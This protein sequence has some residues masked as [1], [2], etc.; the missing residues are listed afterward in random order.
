MYT[1]FLITGLCD[2]GYFNF[3]PDSHYLSLR[4]TTALYLEDA[5][6]DRFEL[7]AM[8]ESMKESMYIS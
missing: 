3:H 7:T 4:G 8:S 5:T 2:N 1:K 6:P